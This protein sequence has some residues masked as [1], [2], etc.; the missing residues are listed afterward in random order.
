MS[1]VTFI[2]IRALFLLRMC[3]V[4]LSAMR[5][6]SWRAHVLLSSSGQSDGLIHQNLW[7]TELE[8]STKFAEMQLPR[9]ISS[10]CMNAQASEA[11]RLTTEMR[12]ES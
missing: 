5:V 4:A 1:T 6:L 10:A 9:R 8:D 2:A 7:R 3:H 11:A 12:N